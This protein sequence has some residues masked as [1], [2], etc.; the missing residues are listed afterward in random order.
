VVFFNVLEL[1]WKK[2]SF[3]ILL[4]VMN[5]ENLFCV[6]SKVWKPEYLL[7]MLLCFP[8]KILHRLLVRQ[9]LSVCGGILVLFVCLVLFFGL[10]CKGEEGEEVKE[11]FPWPDLALWSQT[12]ARIDM[13]L[14]K[15]YLLVTLHGI[16][17]N[18][19]HKVILLCL[20]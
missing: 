2:V 9:H 6:S 10:Q 5:I 18:R 1:L 13:K 8:D 20:K 14:R 4:C 3:W 12:V 15:S 16:F 19:V 11:I 17:L 7:V